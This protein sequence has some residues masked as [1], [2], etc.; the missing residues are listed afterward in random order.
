MR[1]P[2]NEALGLQTGTS[3][4]ST[5]PLQGR[6]KGWGSNAAGSMPGAMLWAGRDGSEI[7]QV[8]ALPHPNPSPE[9]EGLIL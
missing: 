9:G 2:R 5:P 6:G 8:S 4:Y 7:G 1:F 3:P